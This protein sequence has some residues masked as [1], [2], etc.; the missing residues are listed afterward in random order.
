VIAAIGGGLVVPATA[1]G[2]A[3]GLLALLS[4]SDDIVR[5]MGD[6]LKTYTEQHFPW[7]KIAQSYVE[8]YE[9]ILTETAVSS[10]R[11]ADSRDVSA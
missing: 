8:L 10:L 9:R 6:R 7:E 1:E 11:E 4:Q 2:L 5:Q 3:K